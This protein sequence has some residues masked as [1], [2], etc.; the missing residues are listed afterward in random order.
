MGYFEGLAGA[1][2]KKDGDGR[3]IF[4]PFGSL[5]KGRVL[6]DEKTEANLRRWI[7]QYYK[8]LLPSIV[9]TGFISKWLFLIIVP[10]FLIWFHFGIKVTS[11]CPT[12]EVGL[13]LNEAYANSATSHSK[14]SLWVFYFLCIGLLVIAARMCLLTE[15]PKRGVPWFGV[16]FFSLCVFVIGYMLRVK[17]TTSFGTRPSIISLIG[18]TIWSSWLCWMIMMWCLVASRRIIAAPEQQYLNDPISMQW[19]VN[20]VIVGTNFGGAIALFFQKRIA[21][22]LLLIGTLIIAVTLAWQIYFTP[23]AIISSISLIPFVVIPAIVLL[24]SVGSYIHARGLLKAGKL[25]E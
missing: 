13:P 23:P 17:Y 1:L 4:Y 5:G 24:F 6:P 16:A 8:V 25:T 7:I 11:D 18:M 19:L 15:I 9:V 21:P 10:I 3:T 12:A 14:T 2:F 22:K 20:F